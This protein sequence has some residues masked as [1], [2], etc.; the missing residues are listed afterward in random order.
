MVS[1]TER[2]G[3]HIDLVWERS[4]WCSAG[5]TTSR[6]LRAEQSVGRR[7]AIFVAEILR[8]TLPPKGWRRSGMKKCPHCAEE[9]LDEARVCKHCGRDLEEE[10]PERQLLSSHPSMSRSH[11]ILFLL[12]LVPFCGF[13]L[14]PW[15]IL[16]RAKTLTITTKK[17]MLRHGLLSKHT[18]EI[19][20][21]HVRSVMV[22]Q[23]M[24]QRMMGAGT[25]GISSS[26]Q[27]DVEIVFS[28][29][30]QPEGI[31]EIIDRHRGA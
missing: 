22:S 13:P 19:L 12:S 28:G 26:G 8:L 3:P 24:I 15:W 6:A 27:A 23:G 30:S 21:A 31:K 25:I 1:V 9:V 29:L 7:S 16:T 17:T 14:I 5:L 18:S 2:S 4:L 11:P 20:H 10:G